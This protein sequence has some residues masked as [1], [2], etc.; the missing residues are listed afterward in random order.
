MRSPTA[1]VPL[2]HLRVLLEPP[3]VVLIGIAGVAE[4][5][6][7]RALAVPALVRAPLCSGTS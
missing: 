3:L 2:L 7:G 5:R 1:N 4:A 6:G